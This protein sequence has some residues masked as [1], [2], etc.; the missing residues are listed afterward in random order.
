[1]KSDYSAIFVNGEV[2]N[3]INNM[4]LMDLLIYLEF[5]INLIAVEYNAEII[6]YNNMSNTILKPNDTIEIITIVGG[7]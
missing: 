1:M 6:S 7:G 5:D 4:S 2:F 3:C